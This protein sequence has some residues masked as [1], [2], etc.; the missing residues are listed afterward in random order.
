MVS[1]SPYIIV[2]NVSDAIELYQEAFGGEVKILNKK[3]DDILHAELHVNQCVI[4]HI[5]SDYGQET[6]NDNSN[7][8]LTFDEVEAERKAYDTLAEEGNPHMPIERTF[9]NAMHG[10]VKDKYK[11][12]WLMNSFIQ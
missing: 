9:F 4:L 7:I 6:T 8:I 1:L 5:S 2:D 10:Q 12:N 11:V 3:K